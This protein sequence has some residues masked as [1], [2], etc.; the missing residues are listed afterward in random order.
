MPDDDRRQA[1]ERLLGCFD[2]AIDEAPVQQVRPWERDAP[3]QLDELTHKEQLRGLGRLIGGDPAAA[4]WA[5]RTK[6]REGNFADRGAGWESRLCRLS[7]DPGHAWGP[8]RTP[9]SA[10]LGVSDGRSRLA[11]VAQCPL[12]ESDGG[13]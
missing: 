3:V 7:P 4:D 13:H 6:P 11:R 9:G 5:D 2:V 1:A 8:S 10:P 12:T